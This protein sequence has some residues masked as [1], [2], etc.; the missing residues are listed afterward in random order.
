MRIPTLSLA[1]L[2]AVIIT[3]MLLLSVGLAYLGVSWYSAYL[4]AGLLQQLPADAAS[5]YRDMNAGIVPDTKALEALFDQLNG[6]SEP[7]DW[8]LYMSVLVS[9]L[10]SAMIC[11]AIGIYLVR[12]IARPLEQLTRAAQALEGG[13][14]SVRMLRSHRGTREVKSLIE[15][16]NALATSLETMEQRLRFN[17]MAVAHELRTPLT[18]LQGTMQGMV[19]DVFPMEKKALASLLLQA[20][21]LSRI[22]EDLRTLSLAI[23]QQLVT[24]KEMTDLGGL[25]DAVVTSA[26]PMLDAQSITVETALAGHAVSVDAQRIRQAILALIENACHYAACGGSLRFE[27][28]LGTGEIWLRVLDRGPGFPSDICRASPSRFCAERPRAH[29]PPVARDWGSRW[30]RRSL[31][32]MGGVCNCQTGRA[33]VP[34]QR[35]SSRHL[36]RDKFAFSFR[37]NAMRLRC[38]EPA[39]FRK[40]GYIRG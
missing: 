16:F 28:A 31:S 11:S 2:T 19:D 9:G 34:A 25:I 1:T 40:G 17:T 32:R 37:L 39:G 26:R 29:A 5:A 18:I 24:Q 22:V 33:G 12:K 13:D 4:E 21:G 30:F 3:A 20:E 8:H 27:L 36:D 6:F 38:R 10:L 35:W 23:G 14:F 7:L 15:S